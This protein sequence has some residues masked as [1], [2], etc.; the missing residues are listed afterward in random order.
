MSIVWFVDVLKQLKTGPI[1]SFSGSPFAK[2]FELNVR[3]LIAQLKSNKCYRISEI[4]SH[5]LISFMIVVKRIQGG[6]PF[7]SPQVLVIFRDH[8]IVLVSC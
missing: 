3:H 4:N 8:G 5:V 6:G 7:A 1:L 2:E